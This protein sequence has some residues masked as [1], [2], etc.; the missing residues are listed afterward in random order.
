VLEREGPR[1]TAVE[2][3]ARNKLGRK[4]H[5]LGHSVCHA[6]VVVIPDRSM[7]R[8]SDIIG[9]EIFRHDCFDMVLDAGVLSS[10]QPASSIDRV[11]NGLAGDA[12]K[13]LMV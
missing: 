13:R 11:K 1:V 8:A 2:V 10:A 12:L 9:R 5:A 7:S 4:L 3:I 6:G